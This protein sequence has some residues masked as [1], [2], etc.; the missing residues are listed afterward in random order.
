MR[1]L[2]STLEVVLL[3]TGVDKVSALNAFGV[4]QRED[5]DNREEE[6]ANGEEQNQRAWVG[7]LIVEDQVGENQNKRQDHGDC[8][9]GVRDFESSVQGALTVERILCWTRQA[10]SVHAIL[11]VGCG[12]S[13][14]V[15]GVRDEWSVAL[16]GQ[17]ANSGWSKILNSLNGVT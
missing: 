14:S 3:G 13:W 5:D 6:D 1:T 9:H 11:S 2:N 4:N 7:A 17:V 15:F 10:A 12:A 16:C 8:T